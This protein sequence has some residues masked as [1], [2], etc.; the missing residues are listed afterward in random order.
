MTKVMINSITALK[1]F[2][3]PPRPRDEAPAN[4]R[5]FA[6]SKFAPV[7]ACLTLVCA[8]ATGC[9]DNK[10]KEQ[11]PPP[12]QT[13]TQL[14]D[15]GRYDE[16]IQILENDRAPQDDSKVTTALASA[17][18]AR[19]GVKVED[20]WGFVIGYDRLLFASPASNDTVPMSIDVK[21]LPAGLSRSTVDFLKNLNV[22][23]S[24]VNSIIARIKQIPY[25]PAERRGD[26]NHA[27]GVLSRTTQPGARLYRSVLS[28]I[29]LQSE[30]KDLSPSLTE[31]AKSNYSLCDETLA[32]FADLLVDVRDHLFWMTD[33]LAYAYPTK[34]DQFHQLQT[35]IHESDRLFV[36]LKDVKD[37]LP[38]H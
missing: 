12:L 29:V 8:L 19:A 21:S 20:F 24:Q 23:L 36:S 6:R 14:I 10:A 11:S 1:T 33:D 22:N 4:A 3:V 26:L 15:Q 28:V 27:I 17:Y 18:A 31:W 32:S 13:A 34:A 16:A 7:L 35:Q 38:C 37:R 25:V 9:T 30:F 2:C 5:G